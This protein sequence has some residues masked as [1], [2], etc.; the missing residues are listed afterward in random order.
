MGI[1]ASSE[2]KRLLMDEGIDVSGH[3]AQRTTGD[4]LK[5]SDLIFV[6]QRFQEEAIL[7]NYSFLKGRVYLLK[8]FSKFDHNELEIEDPI[9]KGMEVYKT[10]FF[11]IKQALERLIDLV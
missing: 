5:R 3:R 11:S 8:E 10:C 4:L 1:K 2:T 6:M 7:K 9:G